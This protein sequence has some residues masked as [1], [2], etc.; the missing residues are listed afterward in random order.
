ME[1]WLTKLIDNKATAELATIIKEVRLNYRFLQAATIPFLWKFLAYIPTIVLGT[2]HALQDIVSIVC[3]SIGK[4]KWAELLKDP[5]P[6]ILVALFKKEGFKETFDTFI[7]VLNILSAQ[8]FSD[9]AL[10]TSLV[11]GCAP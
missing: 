8:N 3:R 6:V 7:P 10:L 11:N 4:E 2:D 9:K 1:A 5:N